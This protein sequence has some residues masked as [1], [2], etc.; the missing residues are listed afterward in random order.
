MP[1]QTPPVALYFDPDGYI[2][3]PSRATAAPGGPRGHHGPAGRG[4]RVPRRLPHA[5][6]LGLLTAVARSRERAEPLAA[7]C[8]SH[9]SAGPA[10]GDR[11]SFPRADFL[12]A[13]SGPDPPPG[14]LYFPCPPDARFAWARHTTAAHSPCVA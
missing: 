10:S 13:F 7:V 9:S 11:P 6:P 8:Q 5:R 3:A 2:E 1:S 14:V 4:K 12:T